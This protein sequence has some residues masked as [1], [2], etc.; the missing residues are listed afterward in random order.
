MPFYCHSLFA[1]LVAA[2]RQKHSNRA[3]FALTLLH[4]LCLFISGAIVYFIL[5]YWICCKHHFS[6]K[7]YKCYL[8]NG[9]AFVVHTVSLVYRG[10]CRIVSQ[11]LK[12]CIKSAIWHL[13]ISSCNLHKVQVCEQTEVILKYSQW[14]CL[15]WCWDHIRIPQHFSY[16]IVNHPCSS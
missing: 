10:N 16:V 14:I 8:T 9:S 1:L 3:A 15:G 7:R 5:W 13:S 2:R 12:T 4:K 6:V 11:N